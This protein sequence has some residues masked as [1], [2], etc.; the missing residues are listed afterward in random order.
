MLLF[1]LE[2]TP[3]MEISNPIT[4]RQPK[5]SDQHLLHWGWREGERGQ[6]ERLGGGRTIRDTNTAVVEVEEGDKKGEGE[7]GGE[8]EREE[9]RNIMG[10]GDLETVKERDEDRA[11]L[12]TD[13]T[14]SYIRISD[15]NTGGGETDLLG[16]E[17][18][19]HATKQP[20]TSTHTKHDYVNH[21]MWMTEPHA[22]G[23]SE[24]HCK[25]ENVS[26][27]AW[28]KFSASFEDYVKMDPDTNQYKYLAPVSDRF[29]PKPALGEGSK[30]SVEGDKGIAQ[31]KGRQP[32]RNVPADYEH[33]V[34]SEDKTQ[35][36]SYLAKGSKGQST[37]TPSFPGATTTWT[38]EGGMKRARFKKY[39]NVNINELSSSVCTPHPTTKSCF[40]GPQTLATDSS[41][42][43]SLDMVCGDHVRT[44]LTQRSTYIN[45]DG[46]ELPPERLPIP[47]KSLKNTRPS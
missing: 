44:Q 6:L 10:E 23:D 17:A 29:R 14:G 38:G 15:I 8:G 22:N 31:T 45:I 19:Q 36:G 26:T 32:Q 1:L 13:V 21:G 27:E 3:E 9:H 7:R 30:I 11:R 41:E 40:L 42:K 37:G 39:M 12:G 35:G 46:N 28:P 5:Y 18:G 2:K 34:P 16:R 25:Q 33:P 24:T 43:S 4:T 47:L 20:A